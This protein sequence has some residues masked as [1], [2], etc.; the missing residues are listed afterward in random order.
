MTQTT[1]RNGRRSSTYQAFLAGEPEQR[2]NLN[3]ITGAHGDA[4]AAGHRRRPDCRHGRRIPHRGRRGGDAAGRQGGDRL[5]RRDRLAAPADAIRHRT[6]AGT[7]SRRG[8]L[9]SST[10][11]VGKH[12]QD[13]LMCPLM[14]PA[15]GI[16]VTMNDIS[17]VHG[18]RTRCALRPDRCPPIPPT[19]PTLSPRAAGIEGRRRSAPRRLARDRTP[20]W[21]RHRWPTRWSSA[22]PASAI[23]ISHDT[24]II[25]FVTGT[26]GGLPAARSLNIDTARFFDDAATRL[27]ADA[28]NLI[29]LANPVLP[30]SQR[31]HR[32]GK[33]RSRRHSRRSA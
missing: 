27:A 18:T 30:H 7:G 10:C 28:E 19:M 3:I 8:C 13:H 15:P 26:N 6:A 31:R 1:T 24:E 21:A 33:R 16:G 17:G 25:C 2:P 14:Y 11:R 5:R 12:L 22:P 23:P 29:M 4:R 32:P 20:A 9:S